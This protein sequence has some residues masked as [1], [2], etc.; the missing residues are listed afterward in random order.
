M[1]KNVIF[2]L[3]VLLAVS[4]TLLSRERRLNESYS[5]FVYSKTEMDTEVASITGEL[6]NKL[7]RDGSNAAD[8]VTIAGRVNAGTACV[9][10]TTAK[11]GNALTV[12]GDQYNTGK[13]EADTVYVRG[14]RALLASG[15]NRFLMGT[16][17]ETCTGDGNTV[18]G[19]LTATNLTT[20]AC[21]TVFGYHAAQ[22]LETGSFNTVIGQNSFHSTAS[23]TNNVVIGRHS[24]PYY[25]S[26]YGNTAVGTE[27]MKGSADAYIR[28]NTGIGYLALA[29]LNSGNKNTAVGAI[30]GRHKAVGTPEVAS[31]TGCLYLGAEVRSGQ[32]A[33]DTSTVNN[34]IVIGYQAIGHGSNTCTIGNTNITKTVLRSGTC[35]ATNTVQSDYACTIGGANSLYAEGN[36]SAE[37]F[38]DRSD[39]P[40]DLSEAYAI[41]QSHESSAGKVNHAKLH[42]AAWG[43]KARRELTGKTITVYKQEY[44]EEGEPKQV[45]EE[46]PEYRTV[47]EPDQTKRNL[48]M[49]ISAQAMVISDLTR[50]IEALENSR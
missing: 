43:T 16:G 40:A 24:M 1:K 20:G 38:T 29:A 41:I 10:T 45:A 37:S 25:S 30:A 2:I 26:A 11:A 48:S 19:Y 39:A 50:R 14:Q 34:E 27:V 5:P 23:A 9:A 47:V 32:S 22:A 36:V 12:A 6:D 15:T 7:N 4:G 28:D 46:Q 3:A 49:V 35:I 17:N 44:D 31:A 42:P 21:N 33:E 18:C 8:P 13:F